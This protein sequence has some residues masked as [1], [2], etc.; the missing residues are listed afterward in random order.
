M[1]LFY[2]WEVFKYDS[3]VVI[4]D[5]VNRNEYVFANDR[6]GFIKFYNE[7]KNDIWVGFNSRDYDSWITKAVIADFNPYDMNDWIINKKRKGWEFSSILRDVQLY[8]FD[9]FTG[10]Y[11]LKTL[12]AFQ[13]NNIKESSVPFNINRKLTPQELAETISYCKTDVY[14]TIKVFL[15]RKEE[16]D[17]QMALLKEFN[18]SLQH[19]SKKKPK[20]SAHILG[21]KKQYRNEVSY[22]KTIHNLD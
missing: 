10:Y 8:D 1:I 9:C 13:G 15:K 12:E 19:I 5:P 7:H 14:E 16:F 18:L 11:G 17:A 2:D 4:V 22:G 3:L 6:V 21:A 20:L